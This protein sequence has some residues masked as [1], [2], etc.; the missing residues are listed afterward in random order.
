MILL[1]YRGGE[2][3]AA[4]KLNSASEIDSLLKQIRNGSP[5]KRVRELVGPLI[6]EGFVKERFPNISLSTQQYGTTGNQYDD[7]CSAYLISIFMEFL[8]TDDAEIMLMAYGFLDGFVE[9]LRKRRKKYYE[10]AHSYNKRLEKKERKDKDN[11]LREVENNI[12]EELSKAL[13]EIKNKKE[14]ISEFTN[15]VYEDFCNDRIPKKLS[16]PITD[17]LDNSSFV[18]DN[19]AEIDADEIK[20]QHYRIITFK[21]SICGLV[22]HNHETKIP[23]DGNVDEEDEQIFDISK[24]LIT[25]VLA[26]IVCLI[27]IIL[28]NKPGQDSDSSNVLIAEEYSMEPLRNDTLEEGQEKQAR[29]PIIA[30]CKEVISQG[31]VSG[32]VEFP[33]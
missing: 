31:T 17:Y 6:G 15:K 11:L 23:I 14:E 8:S 9:K 30:P 24:E 13:I 22:L 10:C 21:V 7:F 27:L 3:L 25:A 2:E 5:V 4:Y 26:S 19:L 20:V 28:V 12:I 33:K 18:K 16:L 1:Y 29:I 32:S